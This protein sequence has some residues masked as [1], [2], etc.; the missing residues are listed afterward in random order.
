MGA[1]ILGCGAAS[2]SDDWPKLTSASGSDVREIPA[3]PGKS[4]VDPL[5]KGHPGDRVVVH[6]GDA[7]LAAVV[8]RLLRLA[9]LDLVVGYVPVVASSPVTRRWALRADR[10]GG[11][12]TGSVLPVP[13]IRDDLGGVLLGLG[14]LAPANGPVNG[15]VYCDDEVALRGAARAVEVAPDLDGGPGLSVTVVR[16]SLLGQRRA[17]LTGRAAQ[18]GG[19]EVVPVRD[20]VAHPRPV[21]RWTWYRHTDD[22]RICR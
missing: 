15:T 3:T 2:T 6:G 7:D 19:A 16:R 9:R 8:L 18:F 5:I 13:L 10:V 22:L 1:L 17:T 4:D 14:V 21:T 12:L 11:A 20:G